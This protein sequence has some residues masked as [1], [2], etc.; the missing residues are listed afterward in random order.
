MGLAMQ[1]KA[2]ARLETPDTKMVGPGRQ[3]R[4]CSSCRRCNYAQIAP[5][6]NAQSHRGRRRR[7]H[8]TCA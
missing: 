2:L 7:S 5:A 1:E 6:L 4:S 3:T 8:D